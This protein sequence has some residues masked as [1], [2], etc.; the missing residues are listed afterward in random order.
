MYVL[1]STKKLTKFREFAITPSAKEG[2]G[3]GSA[4]AFI[5]PLK[6]RKLEKRHGVTL[7]GGPDPPENPTAPAACQEEAKDDCESAHLNDNNNTNQLRNEVGNG[8]LKAREMPKEGDELKAAASAR[9]EGEA[10]GPNSDDRMRKAE[11][12]EKNK[13]LLLDNDAMDAY[14]K[15]LCQKYF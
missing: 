7:L 8:L 5:S 14:M 11:I 10:A 9:L 2:G 3:L 1:K 15:N 4:S 6:L 13:N 12:D